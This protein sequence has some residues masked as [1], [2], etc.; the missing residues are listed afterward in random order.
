MIALA[1]TAPVPKGG[2]THI[3]ITTNSPVLHKFTPLSVIE[4]FMPMPGSLQAGGCFT[5]LPMA[6]PVFWPQEDDCF[7][8]PFLHR[9][10]HALMAL[11]L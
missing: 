9:I 1:I 5:I 3:Q 11:G 4:T 6:Y 7:N 8:G 10:H 2:V